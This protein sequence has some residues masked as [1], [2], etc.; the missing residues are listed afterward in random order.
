MEHLMTISIVSVSA[1]LAVGIG[2]D[3]MRREVAKKRSES[4]ISQALRRG[5]ANPDGVQSNSLPVLQ[6][7]ACETSAH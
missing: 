5:L 7:H 6:W 1:V 2:L 3:W 4:R